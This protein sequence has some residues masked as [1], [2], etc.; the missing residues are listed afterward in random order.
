MGLTEEGAFPERTKPNTHNLFTNN[1][2][3][4]R[5]LERRSRRVNILRLP[6]PSNHASVE[7]HNPRTHPIRP[8]LTMF[9]LACSVTL[10]TASV[11]L[12]Q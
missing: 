11:L 8:Q 1:W 5:K 4:R 3:L 7:K 10:S 12:G 6:A 9:P 2:I